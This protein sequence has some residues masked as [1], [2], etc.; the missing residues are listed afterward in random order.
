MSYIA[1]TKRVIGHD[2]PLLSGGCIYYRTPLL[3]TLAEEDKLS[4]AYDDFEALAAAFL[5]LSREPAWPP[6]FLKLLWAGKSELLPPLLR[7]LVWSE[8]PPTP[9]SPF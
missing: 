1:G 9:P 8:A 7:W 4:P 6:K 5:M 3:L 2:I